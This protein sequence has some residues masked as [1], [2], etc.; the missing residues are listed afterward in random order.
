VGREAVEREMTEVAGV[1]LSV[2][3][4]VP[5]ELIDAEWQ[6]LRRSLFEQT[7]LPGRYKALIGV[8]VAAALRCPYATRLHTGLAQVHGASEAELAEVVQYCGL[9]SGW[10]A[11]LH[12]LATDP[13][14]FGGEVTQVVGH[15]TS[16]VGVEL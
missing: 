14:A 11:L 9:V 15:L 10:S 5:D 3:D 2:L 4:R 13:A 16:R 7:L 12:G 6:L 8:A 1:V